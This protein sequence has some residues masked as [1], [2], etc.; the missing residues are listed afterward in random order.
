[1]AKIALI[2]PYFG[3]WPDYFPFYLAS[4]RY[5]PALD[6]LFFTDLPAPTDA[7][8]NAR[9]YRCTLDDVSQLA[10]QCLALKVKIAH[11]R[12]LC[13]FKPTY[14][15]IFQEFIRGYEYWACGDIDVIY[16]ELSS[17]LDTLVETSDVISFRRYWASGSLLVHRNVPDVNYLWKK[18]KGWEMVLS[19]PQYIAFD[20]LGGMYFDELQRGTDIFELDAPVEAL[21]QLLKKAEASGEIRCHFE[22][23]ACERLAWNDTLCFDKGRLWSLR[24]GKEHPYFHLVYHKRRFLYAPKWPSIPDR[25]YIRHSG[26]YSEEECR[27]LWACREVKHVACGL[28]SCARRRLARMRMNFLRAFQKHKDDE[29]A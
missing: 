26:I 6:V 9:F 29:R 8:A 2:I 25:F 19:A 27:A 21:T 1:M 3:V 4:L 11:P 24:S 23:L 18:S 22:D 7:P 28:G 13:D 10:S 17:L 20:E 14:G 5:N 15:V 12:K 16:G